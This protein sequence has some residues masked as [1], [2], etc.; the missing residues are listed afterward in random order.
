MAIKINDIPPEGL[1]LELAQDLDLFNRGT[2][3]TPFTAVFSIKPTG[4]GILHI[5]GRIQATPDL[6]CSRCLEH[7]PFGIDT[8]VSIDLAP[9]GSLESDVEH[10]LVS[11]ELD[12]E[13]YHGDEIEPVDI[14]KEHLLISIPMV[15]LHSPDCKGLCS[16]CGAD[17]NKTECGHQRNAPGD[18]GAFSALKDL[19]KK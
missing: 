17:L 11:G 14:I 7:F 19:F 2:A 6:E 1:T 8:E 10:E 4:E 5:S 15:P 13:F 3:T 9:V 12:M 16:I 18:F